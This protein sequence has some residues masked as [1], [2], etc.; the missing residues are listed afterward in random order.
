EKSAPDY[1][2]A[3][4][5]DDV[6]EAVP[7]DLDLGEVPGGVSSGGTAGGG[8]G[9]GD[10]AMTVLAVSGI[11]TGTALLGVLGVWSVVARRRLGGS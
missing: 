1:A 10:A 3:S 8:S 7:V 6:F 11:G 5:P 2:G 9:R 4:R